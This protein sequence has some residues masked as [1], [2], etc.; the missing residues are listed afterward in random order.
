MHLSCTLGLAL[1]K[2][3]S[4]MDRMKG[5]TCLVKKQLVQ[6]EGATFWSI[7]SVEG[8]TSDK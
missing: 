4:K 3:G 1:G 5:A 7:Y 6:K 8:A 2:T